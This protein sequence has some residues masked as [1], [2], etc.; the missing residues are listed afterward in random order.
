MHALL[1]NRDLTWGLALWALV[2]AGWL[3]LRPGLSG[4]FAFD[5]GVNLDGLARISADPSLHRAW[6]YVSGGV[7]STMGRPLA[8]ATFALQH[9]SW[10]AHPGDFIRVNVLLHL[11]SAVLVFWVALEWRRI[12]RAD[13]AGAL[14]PLAIATLW[15]MSPIQSNAVL[16]VVQRMAVLSGGLT[17]LGLLL[18]LKGRSAGIAGRNRTALLLMSAG[19]VAGL[20]L[21]TL[22]KENAALYP[23]LVLVLEA[24]LLRAVARPVHW[25][26]WSGVMLALPLL[27]LGAYLAH[28]CIGLGSE[29]AYR[30]FTLVERLLTEARVLF[31]YLKQ[32]LAPSLYSIRILYDDLPIST[33]LLRPWT[34]SAA[35]LGWALLVG[36]A[37]R[38]RARAPEFSFGVLWYLSA[39][40][41][42]STFL[43]LEL[44]F[45]HRNYVAILGPLLFLVTGFERLIALP[46]ARRVRPALLAGAACYVV[47]TAASLHQ[48]AALWGRPTEQAHYWFAR[49]PDSR[50]AA[51]VF[52]GHLSRQGDVERGTR[53]LRDAAARWDN[54]AAMKLTLLSVGCY[55]AG[56][57]VPGRDEMRT[58]FQHNDAHLTAVVGA[59]VGL[60]EAAEAGACAR[61][62]PAELEELM[63]MTLEA[64]SLRPARVNLRV[65]QSRLFDLHGDRTRARQALDEA[66]RVDPRPDLVEQGVYWALQAGDTAKAREYLAVAAATPKLKRWAYRREYEALRALVEDYEAAAPLP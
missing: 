53:V 29:Y 35:L 28:R 25:R 40:L 14:V 42:E 24:T 17:F 57:A 37:V 7:S 41:L 22:S 33:S 4:D 45:L 2:L 63:A 58:T 44:A 59:L 18:H 13:S 5:D 26:A 55:Q 50:R 23:L 20:G 31:L 3:L 43:P 66:I 30:P 56:L 36:G 9:D 64:P 49:Q 15:M 54:D 11:L 51:M 47:L 65:L 34:T 60:V 52:S 10:P 61:Y 21:G 62:A 12:T 32:L 16:Y 48:T 39:H 1:R 6:Q 8:L 38:L 27:L 46:A 19:V